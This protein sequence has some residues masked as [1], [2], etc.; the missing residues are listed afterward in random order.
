[1]EHVKPA[2]PAVYL[3]RCAFNCYG[4]G[5]GVEERG[6]YGVVGV[7]LFK[8]VVYGLGGLRRSE[9]EGVVV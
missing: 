9:V 2:A 7:P 1:M 5:S 3:L 6:S 4:G 8:G